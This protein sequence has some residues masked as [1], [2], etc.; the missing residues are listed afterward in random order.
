M[1]NEETLIL[2]YRNRCFFDCSKVNLT[3]PFKL[4][5]PYLDNI[6]LAFSVGEY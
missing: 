2:F 4:T 6:S 1:K 5:P 3:S